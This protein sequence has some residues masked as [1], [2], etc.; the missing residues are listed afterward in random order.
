[1]NSSHK[2][3]GC[4]LMSWLGLMD[5]RRIVL[6]RRSTMLRK[7]DRSSTCMPCILNSWRKAGNMMLAPATK[8]KG[9]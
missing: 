8:Y 7:A 2:S 6:K 4:F 9:R 5:Y 3:V 1:M